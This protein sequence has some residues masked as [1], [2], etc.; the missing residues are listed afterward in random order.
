MST[1]C[2]THVVKIRKTSSKNVGHSPLPIP[3]RHSSL[4][5]PFTPSYRCP[6]SSLDYSLG[7]PTN[8]HTTLRSFLLVGRSLPLLVA[9][10]STRS[11]HRQTFTRLCTDKTQ[12]FTRRPSSDMTD[13]FQNVYARFGNNVPNKS[14][15]K[16][17]DGLFCI[18]SRDKPP[19]EYRPVQRIQ[20]DASK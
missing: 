16:D 9:R 13:T 14:Q 2:R 20:Q 10:S 4:R 7:A 6:S 19:P 15:A 12:F 18:R 11:P 1:V 5:S 17:D 3:A 8:L